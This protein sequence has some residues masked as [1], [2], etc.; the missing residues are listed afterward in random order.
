MG[1]MAEGN[2]LAWQ[3]SVKFI[4][5]IKKHG[6]IQLLNIWNANKDRSNDAFKWGDEVCQFIKNVEYIMVNIDKETKDVRLALRSHEVLAELGKKEKELPA[7]QIEFLWRPEYGRFM[8]EGTPGHPYI[9][10]GRQLLAIENSLAKRREEVEQHLRPDEAIM[11]I[12]A[13]PMMGVNTFTAPP[14]RPHGVVAESK[15]LPDEVINPHFRFS[16]LTANIRNR[17]GRNVNIQIPLYRDKN[18]APHDEFPLEVGDANA[19]SPFRI[20]MDAMGFG[21]G[22]CCLQVTFQMSNI[23]EAR[24]VYDQLAV[25]APLLLSLSASSAIFRGLLSDIDVR[26]T[27]ISQAVDDRTREELGLEPLVH[28][29]YQ[30]NKSRYDSIDSYLSRSSMLRPE[31]NDLPLVYDHDHYQTLIAGGMDELLARHF[32]HLFI[33]DPL[34]IY[35]DKIEIDDTTHTDHFEN[36]QSTNWQTMRFKPPPPASDIGWRIEFRPMEVQLTDFENAAFIVFMS[37]LTRAIS[38]QKLNFY[39]PIT[40]VDEN[41]KTAHLRGSV[42]NNKFHFR[43]NVH[44]STLS[45]SV[46]NEYEQMTINEI[47][48]GKESGEFAGLIP[49]VRRYIETLSFD[50]ET[51]QRVNRYL[52]FLSQRASGKLQTMSAWTRNFVQTHPAYQHDSVVS[53]EIA[54]DLIQRLNSISSGKIQEPTLLGDFYDAK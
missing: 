2:T 42:L 9:G 19:I 38:D 53:Q 25:V 4:D 20:H 10:L 24:S 8:V 37:L 26:W 18:T 29:K 11:T 33:R 45:G 12:S 21:M 22:N 36:V 7:D 27:V 44:T 40:K 52:S 51:S 14:A 47:F 17:R 30:I 16:T 49:L 6:I 41:M 23:E 43:K 13:F 50:L 31:Y 15:Y 35:S 54:N 39:I 48:N 32:A 46:D 1:F 34:V 3:D 28:N 5:Y